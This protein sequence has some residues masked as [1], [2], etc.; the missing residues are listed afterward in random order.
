[1][2]LLNDW[3]QP[4]LIYRKTRQVRRQAPLLP[5]DD[6]CTGCGWFD[7]SLELQ[8]GLQ[9]LEAPLPDQSLNA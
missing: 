6:Y 2:K 5:D 4:R 1:M 9:V 3:M 7:S 8:R